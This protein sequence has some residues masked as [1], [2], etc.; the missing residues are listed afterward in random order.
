M[1]F[2]SAFPQ[3]DD[4]A[5]AGRTMISIMDTTLRDGEQTYGV[6]ISGEEKLIIGEQLLSRVGVDRIEVASCRVSEGEQKSLRRIMEWADK[7]GYGDRVE[8]LSFVDHRSSVDWLT[9][10]GCRRMNMLTKGSKHHCEKQLRKTAQEH[11]GDIERTLNYAREHGVATSIYMEDWSNGMSNSPDYVDEMLTQYDKWPLERIHLCDTLGILAPHHVEKFVCDL[12]K[13][14]PRL[15]FEFHGHND[16]GLAT[17]NTLIAGSC[18]VAGVHVTVNGLGERAGNSSLAEIVTGFRDHTTR[19]TNVKDTELKEISR[20]VEAFSGKRIAANTP[21]SGND[22]FT[23]TAG[24]HADGDKKGNLYESRLSPARFGRDRVYALGKLSG[25]S[26]LDFNLNKLGLELDP[27]QRKAVLEKVIE[28]G[29]KKKH[30]TT[31]DLPFLISDLLSTPEKADF[32]VLGCV[33]TTTLLL[34]PCANIRV[35]F[36]DREYEAVASGNGGYDA[37]MTA[38]RSLAPQMGIEIP[39]LVD[40]EIH[41]PPGGSTDALVE[42]TISWEGNLKTRA[43]SSDQ[44]LAAVR[45]TE[46]MINLLAKGLH[47][48]FAPAEAEP[49]KAALMESLT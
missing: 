49:E 8:V 16:Y 9:E 5:T 6:S 20:L 27:E 38:L 42:A 19:D 26:N 48:S 2:N 33:V 23:Q 11:L 32:S 37:F 17:A 22:V 41:I 25:R 28:L 31:E 10:A 4:T 12:V 45:A 40:F 34:K 35:R 21:I 29:D 15:K 30:V 46:R 44:V 47:R 3:S 18:G 24:I 1:S 39:R 14:Y 43:V 7:E 13:R 36:K